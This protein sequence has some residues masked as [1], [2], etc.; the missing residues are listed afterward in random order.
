MEQPFEVYFRNH[1]KTVFGVLSFERYT[2]IP[3]RKVEMIENKIMN[4]DEFRKSLIDPETESIWK[5]KWK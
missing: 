4:N 1:E 2:D 5:R 3:Y